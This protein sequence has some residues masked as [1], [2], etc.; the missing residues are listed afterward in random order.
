MK[1]IPEIVKEYVLE[2]CGRMPESDKEI[3]EYLDLI[4]HAKKYETAYILEKTISKKFLKKIG[5]K[6]TD[7]I[8]EDGKKLFNRGIE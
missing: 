1:T 6:T 4:N 2:T 7:E 3:D 5:I 8:K